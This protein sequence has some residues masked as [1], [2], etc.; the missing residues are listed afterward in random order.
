MCQSRGGERGWLDDRHNSE[1]SLWL[2]SSWNV[3]V[4]EVF[5]H[6]SDWMFAVIA[7]FC[8]LEFISKIYHQ[9]IRF[10][11]ALPCSAV[12]VTFHV[13]LMNSQNHFVA[14]V[15]IQ[16][17]YFN[18]DIVALHLFLCPR[19]VFNFTLSRKRN[20]KS[21]IIYGSFCRYSVQSVY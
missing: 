8:K 13:K 10:Q 16:L 12:P 5:I 1:V 9:N 7:N 17:K 18:K 19:P 4:L 6:W 20:S 11:C 2:K 14:R 3:K 21:C 15:K